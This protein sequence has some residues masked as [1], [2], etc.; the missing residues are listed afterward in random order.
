MA[1]QRIELRLLALAGILA[2][3]NPAHAAAD[4]DAKAYAA[5]IAKAEAGD[6][7]VDYIGLRIQTAARLGY[8]EK[9]WA[10]FDK[11]NS[12]IDAQPEQALQL[13]TARIAQV[14]T[15]F[16]AHIVAQLALKKL[17]KDADAAHEGA[18]AGGITRSIASGHKGTVI[19]DAFNAVSVAEEARV[20]FLLH[21]KSDHQAMVAQGGEYFDVF[22]V[23][24]TRDNVPRKVWFNI[25]AFYGKQLGL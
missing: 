14:W 17:G 10:E 12:L 2:C 15:D 1:R 19:D 7:N 22:D 25:D 11:A 21:F 9:P 18:I 23:I 13:A 8:A 3:T 4:I 24:D 20:L 5:A 6:T 16:T